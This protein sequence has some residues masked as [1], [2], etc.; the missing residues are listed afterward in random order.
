MKDWHCNCLCFSCGVDQK[1]KNDRGETAYEMA[2]R[3]G[4]DN[5]VK[6]FAAALGQSQLQRM[7]RPRSAVQWQNAGRWDDS[8]VTVY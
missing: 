6:R 2:T 4:Y 8:G 5:L 1:V 7:I 3:A